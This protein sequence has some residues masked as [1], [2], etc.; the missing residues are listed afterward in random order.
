MQLFDELN[1][2]NFVLFAS[3]PYNNN[4]CVD[5]EEFYENMK[6]F[7]YLKR[8]FSLYEQGDLQERLVINHLIVLYNV[9]GIGPAN[10]MIFYKVDEKHWPVLKPFLVFLNYLPE[11]EYVDIP[12]DQTIVEKLRAL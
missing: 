8:L 10:K 3:R 4:Q 7:K 9:F 6:R 11:S 5:V 1:N 12:L 2:D